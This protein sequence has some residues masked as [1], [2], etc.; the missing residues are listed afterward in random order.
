MVQPSIYHLICLYLFCA[1]PYLKGNYMLVLSVR[2]SAQ[3]LS[4]IRL[5][6][7][8]MICVPNLRESLSLNNHS[9]MVVTWLQIMGYLIFIQRWIIELSFRN[10]L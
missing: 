7:P 8:S 3:F 10:K 2:H 6:I 1:N 5:I 4:I 9:L